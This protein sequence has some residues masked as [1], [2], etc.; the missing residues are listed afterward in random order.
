MGEGDLDENEEEDEEAP[1][2]ENDIE[3]SDASSY[4]SDDNIDEEDMEHP[5]TSS[6]NV[7]WDNI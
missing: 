3:E 6:D 5:A 1:M 7:G 2:G 4:I